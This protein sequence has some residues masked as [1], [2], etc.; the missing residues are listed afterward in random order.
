MVATERPSSSTKAQILSAARNVLKR[1]GV[2]DLSIRAVASDAGVNLALVHYHFH[3]RD[4]LLLA[5]LEDLNTELL[6]R[7]RDLYS[8]SDQSLAQKWAEAVD[9]YRRDL[10]SGYVRTLLELAAHGYAN[11]EMAERVRAAMRGWQDLLRDVVADALPRFGITT[12][13]PD[14][15]TSILISFWYGMELRHLLGTP[16]SEGHMWRA[17][18]T[19]GSLIAQLEQ[20]RG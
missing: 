17:L 12:I 9:F 19:I 18:E 8:Q 13:G 16:E 5:V 15:L 11:P 3:S 10:D 6:D 1:D 4:G 20:R 2:A 14:E 7:Q